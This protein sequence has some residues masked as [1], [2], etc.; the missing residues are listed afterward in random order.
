MSLAALAASLEKSIGPN[1]EEQEVKTW[2]D[3]GY[4]LLNKIISGDY[5]KGVPGGRIVEMFG[6][7]ASGKTL[8]ATQ[9]MLS[10]QKA[11]GVA[12]LCDHEYTYQ[13][14]FA[15]KLGLKERYS[16]INLHKHSAQN[17]TAPPP[18]STTLLNYT[19]IQCT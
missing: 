15:K 19:I 3:T 8:I 9:L 7:P 2:L 13:M 18:P 5:D 1:D 11:G 10:A 16:L 12:G 14:P 4:P 17:A 6:P